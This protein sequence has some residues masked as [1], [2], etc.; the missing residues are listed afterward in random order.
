MRK[1]AALVMVICL[2][3]TMGHVATS[4]AKTF[5]LRETFGQGQFDRAEFGL[6]YNNV[7]LDRDVDIQANYGEINN[8]VSADNGSRDVISSFRITG[9]VALW[10]QHY[11]GYDKV[12]FINFRNRFGFGPKVYLYGDALTASAGY[13]WEFTNREQRDYQYT[14]H[15]LFR[16]IYLTKGSSSDFKFLATHLVNLRDGSDYTSRVEAVQS[17]M[18]REALSL[19]IGAEW[20]CKN[21]T[22]QG[23]SRI[24][25]LQTLGIKYM[26]N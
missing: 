13:V 2:V 20:T 26:F 15:A 19:T 16:L 23:V 12:A 8:T 11:M 9:R 18:L 5:E 17:V 3:L 24:N 6:R 10:T 25:F 1:I 22:P 21:I 4:E 14:D 7:T